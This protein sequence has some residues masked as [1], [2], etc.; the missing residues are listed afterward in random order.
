MLYSMIVHTVWCL[1]K[2]GLTVQQNCY[3]F[4]TLFSRIQPRIPQRALRRLLR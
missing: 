1:F 2:T 4:L 3:N